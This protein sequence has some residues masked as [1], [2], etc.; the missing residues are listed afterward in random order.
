MDCVFKYNASET[1][2]SRKFDCK[3]K[4]CWIDVAPSD[5]HSIFLQISTSSANSIST[6]VYSYLNNGNRTISSKGE[7]KSNRTYFAPPGDGF[8][9]RRAS[10]ICDSGK[11][12]E[13]KFATV[14]H[15]RSICDSLVSYVGNNQ[16]TE[17]QSARTSK[18]A[19][20]CAYHVLP[21]DPEQSTSETLYLISPEDVTFSTY[22]NGNK[23]NKKIGKTIVV[24]NWTSVDFRMDYE[25][26][27]KHETAEIASIFGVSTNRS[28]SCNSIEDSTTFSFTSPGFP[29]F[30]C[31]STHCKSLVS[32]QTPD[33]M[34]SEFLERKLV[35][36]SGN[37]WKGVSLNLKSDTFEFEFSHKTFSMIN[38]TF[39]VDDEDLLVSYQTTQE[40][41]LGPEGHYKVDI[42]QI[43][44][45]RDCDCSLFSQKI[46]AVDH[47]KTIRIPGH[48]DMLFCDWTLI[49]DS[50]QS[51]KLLS[52]YLEDGQDGDEIQIWNHEFTEVYDSEVLRNPRQVNIADLASADTHIL[53]LRRKRGNDSFLH[54]AFNNVE[55]TACHKEEI[56]E[57]DEDPVAIS[58]SHYPLDYPLSESCKMLLQAQ[59]GYYVSVLITDADI[60][61]FHDEVIFY[62]GETNTD[63]PIRHVTGLQKNIV[64]NSTGEMMLIEFTSDDHNS[65]KGFH[66]VAVAVPL[67][68]MG[69]TSGNKNAT[70]KLIP[71][72]DIMVSVVSTN[73][74]E[75]QNSTET[76]H[77]HMHSLPSSSDARPAIR[78]HVP[79]TTAPTT[80]T[81][82]FSFLILV[83]FVGTLL[84]I[85]GVCRVIKKNYPDS[86]PTTSFNNVNV[87]YRAEDNDS[88]VT[89]EA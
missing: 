89:I 48:C 18:F 46:H 2:F 17:I 31:P 68:G 80:H 24:K 14:S 30:L 15:D 11:L 41:N 4:N 72:D 76:G 23:T 66:L 58:S 63:D 10:G 22:V 83:L 35:T 67:K 81:L 60:E 87:R 3:I 42:Q 36:V 54:I 51:D 62:D 20:N 78:N 1:T 37:S 29:D 71:L 77:L 26:P 65:K 53:F 33:N 52:L 55:G 49:P 44:V 34:T 84:G 45:T 27:K 32:F 38:A 43:F 12:P 9:F 21:E 28:C 40:L 50:Q 73:T 59:E 61:N 69:T 6:F 86:C 79:V 16:I 88:I 13:F 47:M 82:L 8:M 74:T 70:E 64:I 7:Y 19:G 85:F 5:T 57:L 39:V 56:Y 25:K 75:E